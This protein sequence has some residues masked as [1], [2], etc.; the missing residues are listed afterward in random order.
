M[1][2]DVA[3]KIVLKLWR[4]LDARSFAFYSIGNKKSQEILK[5]NQRDKW[6]L[7]DTFE[8]MWTRSEGANTGQKVIIAAH[9][10]DYGALYYVLAMSA[11]HLCANEGHFQD[12]VERAWVLF[13]WEKP[14]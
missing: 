6:F 10:R 8:D 5:R 2:D 9:R 11:S 14:V 3:G 1:T 4:A 7:K 13:D 12:G